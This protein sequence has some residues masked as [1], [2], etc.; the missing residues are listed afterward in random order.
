MAEHNKLGEEAEEMAINYLVKN[1]YEI[2]YCNW[3]YSHYE[4]DII[5]K[6]N[7]LLKFV[8]VKSLKSSA[9]RYPEQGVTKKKFKDL[10]KA[11]DQ[12]L[13]RHAEYRHV[14]FD[15]LSIVVSQ[16]KP[17][18]FFLIEDVFL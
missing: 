15:V 17:P 10:L 8:E 7:D 6:K 9:I 13:F 2:L 18:E 4:I 5:A 16:H 3:R 1:G 12:F 11:A 14:Q